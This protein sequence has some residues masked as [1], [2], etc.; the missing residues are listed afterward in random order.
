MMLPCLQL[1]DL[2]LRE[3]VQQ[4]PHLVLLTPELVL[5]LL[6]QELDIKQMPKL[7]GLQLVVLLV[8]QLVVQ[9]LLGLLVVQV[10]SQVQLVELQQVAM[11]QVQN[12]SLVQILE[13]GESHLL[14]HQQ[15]VLWL[16]LESLQLLNLVLLVSMF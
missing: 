9:Q 16:L 6:V 4:L 13:L 2:Q 8:A 10:H 1:L 12:S 11:Q 14:V 7:L 5:Q 15:Q 3:V